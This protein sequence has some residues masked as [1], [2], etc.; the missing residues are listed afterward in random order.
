MPSGLTLIMLV[1]ISV[2]S[3]LAV[4]HCSEDFLGNLQVCKRN[5][6][7]IDSCLKN[8]VSQ[9]VK[10]LADGY[11]EHGIQPLEPLKVGGWNVTKGSVLPFDQDYYDMKLHN[12]SDIVIES[13][14]SKFDDEN[15]YVEI[16]A[17]GP[18]MY[19]D[20]RYEYYD[21]I[22]N[23]VN[24]T[25]K[26]KIEYYYTGYKFYVDLFGK[27]VKRNGVEYVDITACTVDVLSLD[28]LRIEF[29]SENPELDDVITTKFNNI[30]KELISDNR[31]G[32]ERMYSEKFKEVASSVFSAFRYDKLLP[33]N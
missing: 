23:G 28:L 5:D 18:H 25:S 22:L 30:W 21:A 32:Y 10:L 17:L 12:Y 3:A 20:G 15:F 7:N 27:I 11:P 24:L 29:R 2:L 16:I 9:A 31:E 4:A 8:A 13:V 14:S 33:K 1:L 19:V 26:G 6:R